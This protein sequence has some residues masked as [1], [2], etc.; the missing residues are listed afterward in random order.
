MATA[1]G[2][3]TVTWVRSLSGPALLRV[4]KTQDTAALLSPGTRGSESG[5]H[6][7]WS[8]HQIPSS[9]RKPEMQE[10]LGGDWVFTAS[11]G[12]GERLVQNGP[13]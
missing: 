1:S 9:E 10:A 13:A 2:C 4:L 8:Q 6:W 3:T 12:Q 5:R 11:P 7:E